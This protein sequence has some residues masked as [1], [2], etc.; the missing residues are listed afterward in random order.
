M[1]IYFAGGFSVINVKGREEELSKNYSP[2][3]RLTSFY[4]PKERDIV[5]ENIK[6]IKR[7]K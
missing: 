1:I 6:K 5:V 2:W 4:F 3:N 7:S